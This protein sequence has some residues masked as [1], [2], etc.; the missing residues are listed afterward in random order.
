M[1]CSK[2]TKGVK[3]EQKTLAEPASLPLRLDLSSQ[4]NAYQLETQLRT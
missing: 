4:Q 2:W 1:V 3:K